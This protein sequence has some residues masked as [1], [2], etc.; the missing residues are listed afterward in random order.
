MNYAR[1]K[2]RVRSFVKLKRTKNGM[3]KALDLV[4][5]PFDKGC[6]FC[7]MKNSTY[8]ETLDDVLNSDQFQKINGAKDEIVI[9]NEKQINKSLQQFM[10]QEKISIEI[11][12]ILNSTGSQPARPYGPAKVHK[13]RYTS[14]TCSFDTW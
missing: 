14:L 5:V 2:E 12:Q 8:R 10:K 7:V 3:Q 4:A 13:K 11:F 1:I 6:G 9:K